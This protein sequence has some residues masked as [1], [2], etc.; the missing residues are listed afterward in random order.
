MSRRRRR[1]ARGRAVIGPVAPSPVAT[2]S[3][4]ALE[5]IALA[6]RIDPDLESMTVVQL[7]A[8]AGE[9]GVTLGRARTKAAIIEVLRS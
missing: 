7:R 2:G 1:A 9:L 5:P 4:I 8:R 3:R 6:R